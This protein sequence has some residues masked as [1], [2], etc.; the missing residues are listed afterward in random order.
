MEHYRTT[1]GYVSGGYGGR[2]VTLWVEGQIKNILFKFTDL[3][4]RLFCIFLC[5]CMCMCWFEGALAST[6][7][8][9]CIN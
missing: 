3:Q 8:F 1:T 9:I 2:F 6:A 4:G 5:V 7:I